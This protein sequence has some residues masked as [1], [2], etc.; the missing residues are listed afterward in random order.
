MPLIEKLQAWVSPAVLYQTENFTGEIADKKGVLGAVY[1]LLIARLSDTETVASLQGLPAGATEDGDKLLGLLFG[2]FG[3][4]SNTEQL[5][6]SGLINALASNF[7]LSS[8]TVGA[9]TATA[10]PMAYAQL[11]NVAGNVPLASYLQGERELAV[12][13]LPAWLTALV[14]AGLLGAFGLSKAVESTTPAAAVSSTSSSTTQAPAPAYASPPKAAESSINADSGSGFMK[15][16]LPVVGLAIVGLL[17]WLMLRGCQDSTAPVA[18]PTAVPVEV[19]EEGA[20]LTPATFALALDS[21]GKNAL[22]CVAQSGNQGILDNLKAVVAGT[23]GNSDNCQTTVDTAAATDLPVGKYL[24]QIMGFMMG[25]PDA[26]VSITDKLI[27]FNAPAPAALAKLIDDTKVLVSPDFTV[28]AEPELNA[29]DAIAGS[30]SAANVAMDNLAADAG[31]EELV[32]ALNM[33]IINFAVNSSEV[34]AENKAI[35]DKAAAKLASI[36]NAKLKITG[37]T[38]NDGTRELNQKLSESRAKAV[39][40][41]LVSKGV[42]DDNLEVFGAGFDEPIATNATAQ[43]RFRNRRIEFTIVK[44]GETVASVGEATTETATTPSSATSQ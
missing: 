36:P 30:I 43:G 22:S 13:R 12:S 25:V 3:G 2:G 10:L 39:H 23:F 37:H 42:S 21:T 38:D 6:A 1:G 17:G 15:S 11:N 19:V 28:E 14:P 31:L 20:A 9:L 34:P 5:N 7:N 40:D 44:D 35:L 29:T 32:N 8:D 33:Q 18:A 41:Y 24:P 16:L 26:S 27:R 4:E